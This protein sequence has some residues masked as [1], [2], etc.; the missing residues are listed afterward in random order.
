MMS[1][2][3]YE[4]NYGCFKT[5]EP[6]KRDG[7][8]FP[9]WHQC[10]RDVLLKNDMIHVIESP[11]ENPPGSDSTA[12]DRD[13]YQESRDHADLVKEMM[14]SSMEPHLRERWQYFDPY[15]MYLVL[16]VFFAPQMRMMAFECLKEFFSIKMKENDSIYNHVMKMYGLWRHLAYH[17]NS[18]ITDKVAVNVVLISLP[19]SYKD[20]IEGFVRVRDDRIMFYDFMMC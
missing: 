9:H 20:I 7:S 17:L 10:L 3:Q 15:E 18:V 13:D 6:L 4:F 8:N 5:I 16:R 12:Q 1:Y 2:E 19:A 14:L 11:L